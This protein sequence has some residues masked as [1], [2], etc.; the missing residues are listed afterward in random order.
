MGKHT[1]TLAQ[2]SVQEL[3]SSAQAAAPVEPPVRPG[4]LCLGCDNYCVA[5]TCDCPAGVWEPVCGEDGLTYVNDCKAKC[6][7]TIVKCQGACPCQ[8][9]KANIG[10]FLFLKHAQNLLIA[11]YD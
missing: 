4:E 9:R 1:P 3:L 11:A 2:Q 6:D 5:E 7:N 10:L 8:D